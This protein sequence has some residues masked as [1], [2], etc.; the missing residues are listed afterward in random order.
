[1]RFEELKLLPGTPVQLELLS[2]R[3]RAQV[4]YIGYQ[5]GESV[6]VGAP[7]LGQ[8]PLHVDPGE[9]VRLRLFVDGHAFSFQSRVRDL[10]RTP[11]RM[12]HLE[13]PGRV[14]QAGSRQQPRVWAALPAAVR[15]GERSL[16][17]RISDISVGGARLSFT[18]PALEVGQLLQIHTTLSVGSRS[19][20]AEFSGLVCSEIADHDAPRPA[21]HYGVKFCEYPHDSRHLLQRFVYAE[22]IKADTVDP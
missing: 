1:M 14:V 21:F 11:F 2:T 6:L 4:G 8:S 3:R 10:Q 12:L 5:P 20:A 7:L 9:R 16:Q 19:L 17:A 18:E 15:F 13:P 22:M